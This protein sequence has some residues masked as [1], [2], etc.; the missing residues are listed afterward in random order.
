MNTKT[1]WYLG[2]TK[3]INPEPVYLED[4]EWH[5]GWYWGGGYIGNN[6]FHAHA[7]L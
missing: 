4:F 1:K 6:N 3:G 5:C 2:K 7:F